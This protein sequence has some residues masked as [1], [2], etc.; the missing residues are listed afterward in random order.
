MKKHCLLAIVTVLLLGLALTSCSSD[1]DETSEATS[2]IKAEEYSQL[3]GWW[4]SDEVTEV[5]DPKHF[6]Y[7]Y[8]GLYFTDDKFPQTK[9]SVEP[10]VGMMVYWTST[11]TSTA[12]DEKYT[13]QVYAG[14]Y[15]YLETNLVHNMYP[16]EL[17]LCN[18][19]NGLLTVKA[20][21][22]KYADEDVS[23]PTVVKEGYS[24]KTYRR[25]LPGFYPDISMGTNETGSNI[26]VKPDN[27][28]E[29]FHSLVNKEL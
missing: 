5:D 8:T 20:W 9:Y 2:M 1:G 11:D 16:A 10:S 3:K 24:Y 14:K 23:H 19:N 13:F 7:I 15:G 18:V 25:M 29:Y 28:G 6:R 26:L 22:F 4:V 21:Q 27:L 12:I 17:E